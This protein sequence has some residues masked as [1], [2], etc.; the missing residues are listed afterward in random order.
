MT[1]TLR[2]SHNR[3][4]H[5]GGRFRVV[6]CQ[7]RCKSHGWMLDPASMTYTNPS[8]GLR[9]A[10][11]EVER[12]GD[13]VVLYED[14]Q[15][16]PWDPAPPKADL[17]PGE[18]MLRFYAHACV[19]L[20]AGASSV[21]AD[22][23]LVG[24]AFTRGWWLAHDPP[25]DWLTRLAW[26]DAI[27][28]SHSHS[29]HLNP[30]TLRR[31]VAVNPD[32]PIYV[33]A[34]ESGSVAAQVR[35][36]GFRDVRVCPFYQWV[37]L[38]GGVGLMAIPDAAGRED[39]GVLLEYR[40]YR[41][42][43]TVDCRNPAD[44]NLPEVDVLLTH[45]AGGAS[46]FPVCWRDQYGDDGIERLIQRNLGADLQQVLDMV[47]SA[48][49]RV[50]APIAGYFTERHPAD[51]EIQKCNRKHSAAQVCARVEQRFSLSPTSHPWQPEPGGLLDVVTGKVHAPP[52]DLTLEPTP[53]EPF[54]RAIEEDAD[55]PPLDSL[56]GVQRYFTWAGYEGPLLLH[57]VETSED[58]SECLRAF[59]VDFRRCLV[60][61][62]RPADH[63]GP[64]LRMRVRRD[65][66]RHVLRR[67]LSWEEISIGF[68]ARFLR[69]PDVYN[70]DFWDHF[71]NHLPP[72]RRT[73]RKKRTRDVA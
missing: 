3:C 13:C 5:M 4:R 22:P 17:Q 73:S 18:L 60:S 53:I 36:F 2:A 44:G 47:G 43:D 23:W 61:P 55:F 21:F 1:G 49:P 41:V 52:V 28:I 66:F 25:S 6:G 68:Q 33:P 11:L 34:F 59:Y 19:E 67:G 7:L 37:G 40:G 16:A 57:V 29:D 51:S 27:Y 12:H 39:S 38:P 24:P 63:A 56:D 54:I 70:F 8:G 62:S 42:L 72:N 31:L 10:Q 35:A 14:A 71:Q 50:F 58:F 26:A 32:V 30:H 46:G 45:F 9:Q 15:R 65:V 20:R 69:D 48:K 64:Y